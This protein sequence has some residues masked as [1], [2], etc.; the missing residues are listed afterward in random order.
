MKFGRWNWAYI[1]LVALLSGLTGYAFWRYAAFTPPDS[2]REAATSE[3]LTLATDPAP[4]IPTPSPPLEPPLAALPNLPPISVS[5]AQVPIDSA[6]DA[7][8]KALGPDAYI[9]VF[10]AGNLHN[11][12]FSIDRQN[13]PFW[14]IFRALTKQAPFD[15]ISAANVGND[16][17][18]LMGTGTGVPDFQI[19]GPAILFAQNI[20]YNPRG[21]N[22]ALP[23]APAGPQFTL[24]LGAAVDPRIR[25]AEY[26]Y[27]E[28]LHAVDDLG[29]E[30]SVPFRKYYG[31]IQPSN[32][33]ISPLAFPAL[34][35]RATK[36]TFKC[37]LR[38]VAQL[39]QH[40]TIVTDPEQKV[41]KSFTLGDQTLR[42]VRCEL[43]KPIL[44]LHVAPDPPR[45]N[46]MILVT[47]VDANGRSLPLQIPADSMRS[48]AFPDMTGPCKLVF[49]AP[50]QTLPVELDFELKDVPL[51]AP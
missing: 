1:P 33:W 9:Q 41:G 26:S 27:V 20:T 22:P 15:L 30:F 42:L 12:T 37:R 5:F 11:R 28:V 7:L 45:P 17:L 35:P 46:T 34:E 10:N 51:P 48:A 39:T 50:D 49:R 21:S 31:V 23:D 16:G 2:E 44:Y 6:V 13:A 32:C 40:T 25:V 24:N 19:N 14:E 43:Q 36:A 8:R 29:R 4:G 3:P 38:F 18:V 47:V